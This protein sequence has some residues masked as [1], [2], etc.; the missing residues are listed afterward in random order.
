M[1][2]NPELNEDQLEIKEWTHGFAENVVRPESLLLGS[3]GPASF[4]VRSS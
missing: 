2:F 4:V 3:R 1:E